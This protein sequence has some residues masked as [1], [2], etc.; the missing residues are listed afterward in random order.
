MRFG[1]VTD[2]LNTD[3][4]EAIETAL[5]WGV[6]DFEIRNVRGERFPR[7]SDHVLDELAALRDEFSIRY[8]AVSPGFFKCHLTDKASIEYALG[9][10]LKRTLEFAERCDVPVIICFGFEMAT[11][12]GRRSGRGY[13]ASGPTGSRTTPCAA[14]SR[15]RRT[16]SSIRRPASRHCSSAWTGPTWAPTGTSATC[17]K[18]ARDGFTDGYELVKPYIVNVHAKDVAQLADGSMAWKPIGPGY[19]RLGWATPGAGSRPHRRTRHHREPLRAEGGSGVAQ[20]DH[21]A[22]HPG[23]RVVRARVLPAAAPSEAGASAVWWSR[24]LPRPHG[25][26]GHRDPVSVQ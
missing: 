23:G 9:E 8:T 21:L 7:H 12:T 6:Q 18:G 24:T 17:N 5:A 13:C 19:V 2:E 15:T 11:G 22:A 14:P 1:F 10:G 20:P 4:R 3:P 16:A 25:R 26:C